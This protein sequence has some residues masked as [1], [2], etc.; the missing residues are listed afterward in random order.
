MPDAQ[1]TVPYP[2]HTHFVG[3]EDDLARLH[4]ALQGEG[5]VGI[6]PA[7]LG[8]PTGVT[9]QGGI[10][11]TQLA[12]AYAYRYRGEYPD[13]VYWLNAAE[14]LWSE[15]ANLGRHFL[16]QGGEGALKARLYET[17]R[18]RFKVEEV[19]ELCFELSVKY[20]EFSPQLGI[21]SL[22]R[23]LVEY[24]ER[25]GQLGLLEAAVRRLRG[26][27]AQP[28]AR[29]ELVAYAFIQLRE[30]PHCLLI[31]DNVAAPEVLDEPL[32][33]DCVPGRLPGRLLFTTRRRDL[34][35]F[36]PVELK[37]LPPDAALRLLLRD[38]RRAAALDPTHPEHATARDICA[39]FG[40][41]PLA[42]EIAAAHLAKYSTAPLAAYRDEL[43]QRGARDV[44][45]D[46]HVTVETRHKT[47]L[48]AALEAQWATLGQE[49]QT[50][51]R[52]AGQLPEAAYVPAARLGLLAGVPEE[53]QSF[54]DVT[55]AAAM[56][57]LQ[58]A[59][60]IEELSG[61]QARIHP[62]VREFARDQTPLEET[63]DFRAACIRRLLEAFGD[64]AMLERQCDGRGI[65]A[66]INDLLAAQYLINK[67]GSEKAPNSL[68]FVFRGLWSS[69]HGHTG[70]GN[71]LN[72]LQSY[73]TVLRREASNLRG[74]HK[75]GA[76]SFLIQQLYLRVFNN[77]MLRLF[78]DL[79]AYTRSRGQVWLA[80]WIARGESPQ[81]EMTLTGHKGKLRAVALTPDQRRAISGADD[82]KL[83]VWNLD[84]GQ[85]ERTMTCHRGGVFAV[86]VTLDGR[87][88]VSGES[89]GR[90]R[91]WNLDTGE[92]EQILTGHEGMVRAVA[93]MPDGQRVVSG[94]I[95]G[96]IRIWRLDTG[97]ADRTLIG[98]KG[99]VWAVAVTPDGHRVVSGGGDGIVRVWNLITDVC[100]QTIT[101]HDRRVIAVAVTPNGRQVV[102]GGEDRTVR[103]WNL[104]SGLL[105][106][107]LTGCKGRVHA[108]VVTPDGRRA[109]SGGVDEERVLRIWN[110]DKGTAERTLSG[111]ESGINALA[112]TGD[113]QQVISGG[114][115]GTV[116]VWN[117][118]IEMRTLTSHEHWVKTVAVMPG[119]PWVV[120]GGL[121]G[122][123][124][125]WSLETGVRKRTLSVTEGLWFERWVHAVAVTRDGRCA[126][127]FG[128]K[129]AVRIWNLVTGATECM[130]IG[131]SGFVKAVAVTQD[132]RWAI[133]GGEDG[134][135]RLWNLITGVAERTFTGHIGEVGAVAL[136]ND[137]QRAVSGGRDGTLRVWNVTTGRTEWTL[138]GHM[139]SIGAVAVTAN[140]LR[141]ISGGEDGVLRVWNLKT[142]QNEQTLTGHA[143]WVGGVA[144][145][146]DGQRCIT[147]G[148][149]RTLRLWNLDTGRELGCAVLGARVTCVAVASASPLQVVAGDQA[150][151]VYCLEWVE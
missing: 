96:T 2:E 127:A 126:I 40:Y 49:A 13:G 140:G 86:A 28:E 47:G 84:T 8:N 143:G 105:E 14:S 137:G 53:S 83:F 26:D 106:Q 132:G 112:V 25:R 107:T 45:A 75:S 104:R 124:R 61:D 94:A 39:T 136:T 31:L 32:T 138:T 43:Q 80:R 121:D 115:D 146:L 10:G 98:H 91:V 109:I 77:D 37:T 59:S 21:S 23:E 18:A 6:N 62:L 36:Q 141:A 89:D 74:W 123:V 51:L 151:N 81:L 120:S 150:G 52:V 63:S 1:F 65:D 46:R 139:S 3:R 88:V 113:G 66:L 110:L 7:A 108:V 29:D 125:L 9:G 144:V 72:E 67:L 42:L 22:A 5:P 79:P 48:D 128:A 99:G 119:S 69:I 102:S 54:F 85:L 101:A 76:P 68:K 30:R 57:E 58:D 100:E 38:P 135:V 12:V 111:H 27:L 134:T 19:R 95:D 71:S 92:A 44:M 41:L 93:V 73:L 34:G 129:G 4:A 133:T 78:S 97:K 117:L 90:L 145:T 33:G 60:L 11:K 24:C 142:G 15:F 149:D 82:G 122:T 64:I 55:L 114:I 35:R 87:R 103:V 16:G 17:I 50:L 147:A 20:E 118:K 116:R 130:L 70:S 148:N 56:S 131:H